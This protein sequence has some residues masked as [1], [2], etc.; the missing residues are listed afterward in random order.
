MLLPPVAGAWPIYPTRHSSACPC[1]PAWLQSALAEERS[2]VPALLSMLDHTAPLLRAKGVVAILLLCRCVLRC[3]A[4]ACMHRRG[5]TAP[6]T[7][8]AC[9]PRSCPRF[10]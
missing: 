3:V 5:V 9:L 2:L 7:R 4:D 1:L 8:R 10:S 6:A